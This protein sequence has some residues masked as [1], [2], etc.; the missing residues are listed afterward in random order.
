MVRRKGWSYTEERLLLENYNTKTIKELEVILPGREADSI[1]CKIKRMKAA[2]KIG[3]GKDLD[4]KMRAY[5]QRG[6]ETVSIEK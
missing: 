6:L 3:E 4:T 5:S 1:N 2:G